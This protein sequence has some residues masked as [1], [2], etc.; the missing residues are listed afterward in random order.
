MIQ[1]PP[2]STRTDTRFPY[3]TLF[4]SVSGAFRTTKDAKRWASVRKCTSSAAS[5]WSRRAKSDATFIVSR[6]VR[7]SRIDETSPPWAPRSTPLMKIGRASGR[8]REWQY[9]QISGVA[10][11]LKKTSYQDAPES[12]CD[13]IDMNHMTL[14]H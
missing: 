6:R 2:I 11:D 1:R 8:E 13:S 4:R 5:R 10:C 12:V 14:Y 7:A 9:V 3:T